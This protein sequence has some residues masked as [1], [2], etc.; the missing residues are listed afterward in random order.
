MRMKTRQ[1]AGTKERMRTTGREPGRGKRRKTRWRRGETFLALTGFELKKIFGRRWHW[2]ALLGACLLLVILGLSQA[3]EAGESLKGRALDARPIDEG[4][5]EE[6]KPLLKREKGGYRL[7]PSGEAYQGVLDILVAIAG[8]DA[9][10]AG[11][12]GEGLYEIRRE[13]IAGRMEEQ[14]LTEREIAFWEAK[15]AGVEKPFVYERHEGPANLLRALQALGVFALLLLVSGLSGLYAREREEG[16][17]PLILSSRHGKGLLFG[18]KWAAGFVWTLAVSSLLLLALG[19]SYGMVYGM[20]G[21]DAMIQLLRPWCMASMTMG[22]M[23]AIGIG[24]YLL[25]SFMF[26]GAIMFLSGWIRSTMTVTV[27]ML[28]YLL[29]DMFADFPD[30]WKT[31]KTIWSLRPGAVLMNTGSSNLRLVSVGG[32]L[33][34]NL[35]AAPVCYLALSCLFL[36]LGRRCYLR[37]QV[38]R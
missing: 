16:M 12:T 32:W 7:L 28:G 17:D 20:E 24:L 22:Q 6:L 10:L 26:A 18:C 5:L 4:L 19:L 30:R 38:G 1:E 33:L 25:S 36:W 15:E 11:L 21:M 14:G 35:E 29:L 34:S 23:L 27:V 13:K 31:L 37:L 2:G 3:G 8:K 9:D